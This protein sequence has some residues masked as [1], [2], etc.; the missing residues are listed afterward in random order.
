MYSTGLDCGGHDDDC[1]GREVHLMGVL[2]VRHLAFGNDAEARQSGF[3]TVGGE[4]VA[5]LLID[6]RIERGHADA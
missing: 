4:A 2:D 3:A 1:L 6:Q 5:M